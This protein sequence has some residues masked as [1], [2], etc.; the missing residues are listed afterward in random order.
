MQHNIP[1]AFFHLAQYSVCS[2]RQR[3]RRNVRRAAWL[4]VC[5]AAS[6]LRVRVVTKHN[7]MHFARQ[8]RVRSA[9]LP[10]FGEMFQ[11]RKSSVCCFGALIQ[12]LRCAA[13]SILR[14][15]PSFS[16][17]PNVPPFF[18]IVP[19]QMAAL[20]FGNSFGV[21]LFVKIYRKVTSNIKFKKYKIVNKRSTNSL[22]TF[23]TFQAVIYKLISIIIF[24][25]VIC[26]E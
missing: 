15:A 10:R 4:S 1:A 11:W 20:N 8:H 9:R 16:L 18:V 14:A 2:S 21:K 5:G 19:Q 25:A 6:F 24:N 3:C 22:C 17:A 26:F 13:P 7:N 23:L 12:H